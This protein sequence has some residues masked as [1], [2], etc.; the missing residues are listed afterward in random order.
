MTGRHAIVALRAA[1][2]VQMEDVACG[3]ASGRP[4]ELVAAALPVKGA[5][6][7]AARPDVVR[8]WTASLG[9]PAAPT[10]RWRRHGTSTHGS[11]SDRGLPDGGSGP[12]GRPGPDPSTTSRRWH[13]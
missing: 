4:L 6:G 2:A 9:G 8:P 10:A 1:R 11:G 5:C 7:V 13:P 12:V 3:D